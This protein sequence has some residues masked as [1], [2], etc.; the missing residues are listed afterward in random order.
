MQLNIEKIKE[1]IERRFLNVPESIN[2][3]FPDVL[4]GDIQ[5]VAFGDNS[6]SMLVFLDG[7]EMERVKDYSKKG[8]QLFP[9][10]I[11]SQSE[12]GA[13]MRMENSKYMIVS[14][15]TMSGMYSFSVGGNSSFV[16]E[17]HT[18]ELKTNEL[19]NIKYT[20]PLAYVVS[21][22]DESSQEEFYEN[23][24]DLISYSIKK[25]RETGEPS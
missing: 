21:Y 6:F 2:A 24:D 1:I 20:V 8:L 22:E 19:G 23:L 16:I 7:L 25:W 18:Q 17:N 10:L 5:W 14:G 11:T 12:I 13:G 4:K 3:C 9:G 15:C